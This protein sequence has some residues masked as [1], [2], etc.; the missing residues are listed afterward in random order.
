MEAVYAQHSGAEGCPWRSVVVRD[1]HPVVFVA[2]G[3]HASC[4]RA[5]VRD[6]TWP[7]PNDEADGRGDVLRPRVVPVGAREPA[8]IAWRGRWGPS[9]AGI[10][11]GE[12]SSPR[13]PAFQGLSWDD[14]AAFA[15][16]ARP[17][18][19][20]RCD[21]RGECDGRETALDRAPAGVTVR[22]R[23]WAA[24]AGSGTSSRTA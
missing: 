22:A 16:A 18:G 14:P 6:R 10:V 2:N 11:P 13:G 4:F 9:R 17:C 20:G 5:G 12:Q 7:D 21:A 23:T 15:R 1:G 24:P 3:S 8:W 19:A